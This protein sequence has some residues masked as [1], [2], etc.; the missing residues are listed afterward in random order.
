MPPKEMIRFS[1]SE[2]RS[3]DFVNYYTFESIPPGGNPVVMKSPINVPAKVAK[4]QYCKQLA[5]EGK[6]YDG[7]VLHIK[8]DLASGRMYIPEWD[9]L[10][11][12]GRDQTVKLFTSVKL[13][14]TKE[15]GDIPSA[16]P[17]SRRPLQGHKDQDPQR[18]PVKLQ[19]HQ[20]PS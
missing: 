16:P 14:A 18:L 8:L 11:E 6:G 3:N 15:F 17:H 7:P 12:M 10:S 9:N 13:M 5:N 19:V 2:K 20:S 4:E 1:W